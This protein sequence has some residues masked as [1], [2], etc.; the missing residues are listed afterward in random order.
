MKRYSTCGSRRSNVHGSSARARFQAGASFEAASPFR[1]SAGLRP[2][3]RPP[4]S[5]LTGRK[6]E[7]GG[8]KKCAQLVPNLQSA[9]FEKTKPR[10]ARR[11]GARCSPDLV[12]ACTKETA[13]TR[14][15]ARISDVL[16]TGSQY[17]PMKKCSDNFRLPPRNTA[18]ENKVRHDRC[19][20]LNSRKE[21]VGAAVLAAFTTS[22]VISSSS[23]HEKL[24]RRR[25]RDA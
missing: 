14:F 12:L 21:G 8:R 3:E 17:T 16:T 18:S 13:A 15:D 22:P 9:V 11:G 4:R 23:A 19:P 5:G 10:S 20:L 25:D 2:L 1:T 24:F 6:T 7:L